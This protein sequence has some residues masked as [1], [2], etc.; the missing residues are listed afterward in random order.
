MERGRNEKNRFQ[1]KRR[2]LW[3]EEEEEE[4]E[5]PPPQHPSN[6]LPPTSAQGMEAR[7]EQNGNYPGQRLIHFAP[8]SAPYNGNHNHMLV[9]NPEISPSS[10]TISEGKLGRR[11]PDSYMPVANIIR[12][13]RR[14]LPP[15]AKIADDVKDII[16][17]CLSEFLSFI[18]GEANERCK[19]EQRKTITAEDIVWSMAKLGFDDYVEPLTVYL[20]RYREIEGGQAA[21]RKEFIPIQ[22]RN[23]NYGVFPTVAASSSTG[24]RLVA[25]GATA[26][27]PMHMAPGLMLGR[28]GAH[29]HDGSGPSVDVAGGGEGDAGVD[30]D[31]SNPSPTEDEVLLAMVGY[32]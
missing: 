4:E 14:G 12:V 6:V 29:Y 11:K 10:S 5:P 30:G 23:L 15:Q 2:H 18:T 8:Y 21:L 26:V 16:Q 9:S 31:S 24:P 28:G 3:Q 13:M 1:L 27:A 25:A 17:E 19:N 20:K 22:K 32:I 7:I